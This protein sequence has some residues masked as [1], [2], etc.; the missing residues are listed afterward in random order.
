[1]Q[2]VRRTTM[3]VLLLAATTLAATVPAA[4]RKRPAET[5]P[6]IAAWLQLGPVTDAL[7]VFHDA[8]ARGMTAGATLEAERLPETGG[9]VRAGAVVGWFGGLWQAWTEVA[10]DA[11][12]LVT[13]ARPVDTGPARPATAWL[14]A[15]ATVDRLTEVNTVVAGTRPRAMWVDGARQ[16]SGGGEPD[17]AVE[18][19]L[20][21]EPGRHTFVLRSIDDGEGSGAWTLGLE[22]R[23][24][25]E[26]GD[27][28]VLAWT[29]DPA[30][31]LTILDVIDSPQVRSLALSPDGRLAALSLARTVAGT[32]DT[33]TW[34]EVRRAAD[35]T[36]VRAWRGAG[37]P[38]SVR[39]SPTGN[40]LSYIGTAAGEKRSTIWVHD[41]DTGAETAIVE[42]VEHL[43]DYAWSPTG[44][45]VVYTTTVEADKDETGIK[46]LQSL[47]D[48]QTGYRDKSVLHM[49]TVP[50]GVRRQL[51][52][53]P[54][55]ATLYDIAPDGRRVLFGRSLEDLSRRPYTVTELWEADLATLDSRRLLNAPFLRSAVY[56]PDGERLLVLGGPSM[57]ARAGATTPPDVIPNDY[58]GQL[59]I[60]RPGANGVDAITRDFDPAVEDAAWSAADDKIYVLAED[61]DQ[62]R[63]FRYDP[64]T[65]AYETL[66][67]GGIEVATEMDVATRTPR[68]LV[69]GTGVWQGQRVMLVEESGRAS[70][71][72][73]PTAE[74]LRDVRRGDVMP[75]SFQSP[76]GR[77]IDGR[78]YLPTGFDP[79]RKYPVIVYYYGGTSPTSRD[80]GGRY[81]KEWWAANGYVVYVPQPAGATGYGQEFSALHVNTWGKETVGEILEGTKQFL[82]AHP[83]A[84]PAR[85]GC[86]GASYGG[87]TTMKIVSETDLFAAAVAHAGISAIGSYWGEGYWGYQYSAVATADSF[88]WNRPDV[89]VDQSPLFHADKIK[90]PL[91]L[92]H[93]DSDTN[94][95]P[96]ESDQLFIAL[97]LLGVPVEYLSV[98]GQNH[99]IMEHDK[100]VLWSKSIVAWFDRWLK[101]R[102]EWWNALYPPEA[103]AAP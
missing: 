54:E 21:L 94:V 55:S 78:V 43:T 49:V 100:R 98:E 16:A 90:T 17:A 22:I 50:G 11:T 60:W 63:I 84:D 47:L 66:D 24:P 61:R 82:A 101:D 39:W 26:D 32:D 77:T 51:T 8:G 70:V 45:T 9:E 96:G 89:Y 31:E 12:G 23:P 4:A 18:A 83:F 103:K 74:R 52:A 97:R 1:M 48:R 34:V 80:F 27:P 36:L 67:L 20:R 85:V 2:V 69:A 44:E 57:F 59:Y 28:P 81:P 3:A 92:T 91:L 25:K 68:V 95:P 35:G 30:R 38:K 75:F 65:R 56:A 19:T 46:R 87:F 62:K 99:A 15:H 10:P 93:G 72:A 58:D 14:V 79:D 71:V 53:G 13:F 42:A 6:P 76:K 40:R 29:I 73:D 37:A 88:P 7:P 41:L 33:E 5:P 86:I 64:G 102:A